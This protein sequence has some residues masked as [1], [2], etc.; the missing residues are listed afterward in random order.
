VGFD[1]GVIAEAAGLTTIRQPF[2]KSGQLGARLISELIGG[3]TPEAPQQIV[4][5]LELVM[6]DST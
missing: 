5:G 3:A 1:D 2:E 6:R 4:L